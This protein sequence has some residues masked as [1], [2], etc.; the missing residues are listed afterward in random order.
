MPTQLE[1]ILAHTLHELTARRAAADTSLL[2]RK[3]AAHSPARIRGCPAK[4][5]E[6][7]PAIIAEL[8]KGLALAWTHSS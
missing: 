2:Q 1:Q 7:G 4:A 6:F 8:E 5:A 3:A